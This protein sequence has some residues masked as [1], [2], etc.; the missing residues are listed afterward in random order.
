[1]P[2]ILD[3]ILPI[4]LFFLSR[5]INFFHLSSNCRRTRLKIQMMV[6]FEIAKSRKDM[7]SPVSTI[8]TGGAG[9]GG[10][11]QCSGRGMV[12][13]QAPPRPR[14]FPWPYPGS[15]TQGSVGGAGGRGMVAI[16]SIGRPQLYYGTYPYQVYYKSWLLPGPVRLRA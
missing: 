8:S 6:Q 11:G 10:I 13:I 9:G 16:P 2:T 15:A 12:A 5:L 1:M 14:P 7:V 4:L 3:N